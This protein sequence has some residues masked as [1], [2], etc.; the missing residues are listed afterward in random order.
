MRPVH[1]VV[2]FTPYHAF[3]AERLIP[4]LS[5]RVVCAFT[6]SWPKVS[7]YKRA[8]WILQTSHLGRSISYALSLIYFLMYVRVLI[9]FKRPIHLYVPHPNN[10]FSHPLFFLDVLESVNIYEDGLANY[11]DARS[12]FLNVGLLSRV[13]IKFFGFKISKMNGH[14]AG[15]DLRYIN[16]LYLSHGD[17]A[18]G[19]KKVGRVVTLSPAPSLTE[20]DPGV[21]LFLDQNTE[22]VLSSEERERRIEK[23][24]NSYNSEIFYYKPHHDFFTNFKCMRQLTVDL[25]QMP[26]EELV[27]VLSAGVVVSFYSSALINIKALYPRVRCISIA[28]DAIEIKRDGEHQSLSSLFSKSGIECILEGVK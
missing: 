25:R 9:F 10:A 16:E 19:K 24:L 23:L 11:Y 2:G 6:K 26:A 22:G 28:A 12:T 17:L 21:V 7:G 13:I 15:Y 1:L 27:S 5:G 14:L 18:V 3:F 4:T 20:F 8:A